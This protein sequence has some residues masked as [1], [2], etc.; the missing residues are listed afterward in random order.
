MRQELTPIQ[1]EYVGR[2]SQTA[3]PIAPINI[4]VN[5]QPMAS[6]VSGRS[7]L[8][9][10]LLSLVGA[11]FVGVVIYALVTGTPMTAALQQLQDSFTQWMTMAKEFIHANA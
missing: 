7:G 11:F 9:V 10:T 6:P 8:G 3:Q 1:V 4:V 5:T 2:N